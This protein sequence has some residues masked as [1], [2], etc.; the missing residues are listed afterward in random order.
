M[1]YNCQHDNKSR[2]TLHIEQ[3]NRGSDM[4][5]HM[6][7]LGGAPGQLKFDVNFFTCFPFLLA[8]YIRIGLTKIYVKDNI[9]KL[10]LGP[11]RFV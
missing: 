2:Y 8:I 1:S 7:P 9:L 11:V 10:Y 4:V 6:T 3:P 5:S